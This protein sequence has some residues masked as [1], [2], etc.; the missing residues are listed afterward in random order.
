MNIDGNLKG[1]SHFSVNMLMCSPY[2][3]PSSETRTLLKRRLLTKLSYAEDAAYNSRPRKHDGPCPPDTRAK[4]L[5]Q[6]MAWGE[7]PSGAY[8]FWLNGMTGTDKSTITRTVARD[9]AD[10]N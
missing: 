7:D 9:F 6:V 3:G 2:C 4:L 8:I 10:Q 5:Q 1:S